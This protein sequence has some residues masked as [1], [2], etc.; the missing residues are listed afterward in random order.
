VF[1]FSGR[2]MTIVRVESSSVTMMF[3][4]MVFPD[5]REPTVRQKISN[6]TEPQM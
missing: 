2:R 1:F 6:A 4:V 3:S 5:E